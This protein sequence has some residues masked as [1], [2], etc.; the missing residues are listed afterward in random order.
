MGCWHFD[1]THAFH[2]SRKCQLRYSQCCILLIITFSP[3][4]WLPRA[5]RRS[6]MPQNSFKAARRSRE[7]FITRRKARLIAVSILPFPARVQRSHPWISSSFYCHCKPVTKLP[8]QMFNLF[9]KLGIF[10]QL[11][12]FQLRC[13]I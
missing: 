6:L 7:A 10:T 3:N 12:D 5:R 9:L 4:K 8:I 11:R 2:V 1:L 13:L